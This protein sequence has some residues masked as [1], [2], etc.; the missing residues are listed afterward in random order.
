M[1]PLGAKTSQSTFPFGKA[2]PPLLLLDQVFLIC[3]N[4]HSAL[5]KVV[6]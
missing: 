4:S 3:I 6:S 2:G 5:Y 1:V